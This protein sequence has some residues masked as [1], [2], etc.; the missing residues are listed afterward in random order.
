MTSLR[1]QISRKRMLRDL[2]NA[3]L[4]VVLGASV[5]VAAFLATD[6]LIH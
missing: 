1:Q 5:G 4:T 6:L 2:L 3:A